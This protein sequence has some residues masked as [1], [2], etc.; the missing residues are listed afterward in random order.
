[1]VLSVLHEVVADL[2]GQFTRRRDDQ[3][4]RHTRLRPAAGQ[5]IDSVDQLGR[6]VKLFLGRSERVLMSHEG[7]E[8]G[9]SAIGVAADLAMVWSANEGGAR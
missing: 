3:R 5:D 4:A 7:C 2:G 1:M 9:R 6:A 8:V